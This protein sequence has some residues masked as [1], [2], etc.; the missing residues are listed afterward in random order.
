MPTK[1]A[2]EKSK[3]REM[4]ED[5]DYFKEVDRPDGWKFVGQYEK[6]KDD[7]GKTIVADE[8]T[9]LQMYQ[10]RKISYRTLL[11][12]FGQE[13][14]ARI[15]FP[16]GW[17]VT[18]LA[19]GARRILKIYGKQFK[20][21]EGLVVILRSPSKE[22]FIRAIR[23]IYKSEVDYGAMKNLVLQAENTLDSEK[24]LLLSDR[25]KEK[26]TKSGIILPN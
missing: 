21:R 13:A 1:L 12:K 11:A 23:V 25:P 19:T 17:E 10:G 9:L 6:A 15:E 7:A 24:G 4:E 8:K 26:R 5:L 20:S 14:L 22:V 2:K 3:K 16:K 18:C